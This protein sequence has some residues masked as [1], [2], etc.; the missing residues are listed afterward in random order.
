MEQIK[1]I[2]VGENTYTIGA[3]QEAKTDITPVL[4]RETLKSFT[5]TEGSGSSSS[6]YT[7]EGGI[8]R[9]NIQYES[10]LDTDLDISFIP[11]EYYGQSGTYVLTCAGF[12]I[13]YDQDTE[14]E[15]HPYKLLLTL[16][17]IMGEF[18]EFF[19]SYNPTVEE[20]TDDC[21]IKIRCKHFD[22]FS[23]LQDF[24]PS[25]SFPSPV[26]PSAF[27]LEYNKI[28]FGNFV[29]GILPVR[30]EDSGIEEYPYAIYSVSSGSWEGDELVYYL[31]SLEYGGLG[32]SDG[33]TCDRGYTLGV[34]D[35]YLE[36]QTPN[37]VNSYHLYFILK[38]AGSIGIL[39]YEPVTRMTDLT[40]PDS[41]ST[42]GQA[43]IEIKN[44]MVKIFGWEY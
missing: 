4:K 39:G 38:R 33:I 36:L 10:A 42:L 22:F 28:L 23:S 17:S 6:T 31:S 1:T 35:A 26:N 27:R 16:N 24:V 18:T 32:S 43:E 9:P 20:Y 11:Q 44:N 25:S 30:I 13:F 12:G 21:S 41:S 14:I 37:V 15:G 8:L 3:E 7:V 29:G 40:Q 34:L 2:Q 19:F 5:Y